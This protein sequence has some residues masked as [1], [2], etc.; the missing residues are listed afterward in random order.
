MTKDLA[1]EQAVGSATGG[2]ANARTTQ[3]YEASTEN[4]HREIAAAFTAA[5][6]P[7]EI[8]HN[9][10]ADGDL[11]LFPGPTSL[12]IGCELSALPDSNPQDPDHADL[13]EPPTVWVT[14]PAFTEH[15]PEPV[16]FE[17]TAHA[18]AADD[19][20]ERTARELAAGRAGAIA[21]LVDDA[22]CPICSDAYPSQHL[23]QPTVTVELLVCPACAF[24]GDLVPDAYPEYLACQFD[25]LFF[26]DLAAPAGWSGA[27][28]LLAYASGP[29]LGA[30][31]NQAYREAGQAYDVPLRHWDDPGQLWIWLP[32][33][34][35]PQALAHL[36][37]GASLETVAAAIDRAHPGLHDTFRARLNDELEHDPEEPGE[38]PDYLVPGLWNAVIAYACSFAAQA[39]ERP[40]R[41][42]PW[43]V[44]ASFD[45]TV[46][47][48]HFDQLGSTL[49]TDDLS[50]IFTLRTGI[51]VIRDALGWGSSGSRD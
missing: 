7:V 47:A 8:E 1:R 10:D 12:T 46:L 44:S 37:P 41:R 21:A 3:A 9:R 19:V 49:A 29:K 16:A 25:R 2:D 48:D 51:D 18:I 24:D 17:I 6:W 40:A 38:Q 30:R 42:A 32:T 50:V 22:A 14:A 15:G 13:S 39:E 34:K 20:V 28:A 31:L 33:A 43:H 27:A 45:E 35:R 23:L 11:H 5:G 26:K 4:L 36:G